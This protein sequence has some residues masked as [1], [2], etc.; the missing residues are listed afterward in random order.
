MDNAGSVT[1]WLGRLRGG[2]PD[3]ADGLWERYFRRL[4]A[5]ARAR[6]PAALGRAGGDEDVALDAF[7]SLWRGVE[8]GRFAELASRDH[9]WR[10]LVVIT[11]RKAFR[12]ART[13]SRERAS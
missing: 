6:L 3:A 1:V 13:E 12:L 11:L 5:L 2:D 8:D 9:L 7:A 4:Q 10:L